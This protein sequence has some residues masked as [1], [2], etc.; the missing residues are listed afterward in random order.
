MGQQ[1]SLFGDPKKMIT[2]DGDAEL[3]KLFQELPVNLASQVVKAAGVPGARKIINEA[4]RN[5]PDGPTGNL[6]RSIGVIRPRG[7][8]PYILVGARVKKKGRHQSG[9]H[10][11]WIAYGTVNMKGIGEWI[12]EAAGRVHTEVEKI[13]FQKSGDIIDQRIRKYIKRI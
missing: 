6:K 13:I 3:F 12:A 8:R 7:A 4:R 11:G 1:L 2:L 10:A 5:T 9:F